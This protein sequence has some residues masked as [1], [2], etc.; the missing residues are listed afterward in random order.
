MG[1]GRPTCARAPRRLAWRATWASAFR[2]NFLPFWTFGMSRELRISRL[3]ATQHAPLH[4]M[5]A[6]TRLCAALSEGEQLA[7]SGRRCAR[8]GRRA[9]ARRGGG[10]ADGR[11][12]SAV[13]AAGAPPSGAP[14]SALDAVCA[15]GG[16]DPRTTARVLAY[17]RVAWVREQ[18]LVVELGAEAAAEQTRA[19]LR[20]HSASDVASLPAHATRRVLLRVPARRERARERPARLRR[21]R[22]IGRGRGVQRARLRGVDDGGGR[23]DGRARPALRQALL[24]GCAPPSR[25]RRR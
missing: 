23:A 13:G 11:R 15:L 20:R 8:L 2:A 7:R 21:V 19:L 4:G 22:P 6:A 14:R 18:V 3:D 16:G 25:S 12:A 10:A 24:G 17:A 1:K 5:N 9:D